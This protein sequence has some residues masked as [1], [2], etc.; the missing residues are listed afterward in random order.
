MPTEW[1]WPVFAAVLVLLLLWER[2]SASR[3][4]Q[5]HRDQVSELLERLHRKERMAHVAA[6]RPVEPE[7][8]PEHPEDRQITEVGPPPPNGHRQDEEVPMSHGLV[9]DDETEAKY[10]ALRRSGK[11]PDEIVALLSRG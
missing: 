1:A 4:R 9:M 7:P 6:R 3:E 2:V 8:E 11:T 10:E 5:A